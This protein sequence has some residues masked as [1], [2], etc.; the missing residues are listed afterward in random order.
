MFNPWIY[1]IVMF[2]SVE[3]ISPFFNQTTMITGWKNSGKSNGRRSAPHYLISLKSV[4]V[5]ASF[6]YPFAAYPHQ[7]CVPRDFIC[8]YHSIK[9]FT[10][11]LNKTTFT[12]KINEVQIISSE[13]S[14]ML[15]ALPKTCSP[16]SRDDFAATSTDN[17]S[18][19][20]LVRF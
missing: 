5:N 8:F 19:S 3:Q 12:I 15:I 14:P 16:C 17:T 1:I 6:P 9:N 2:H 4:I 11:Y 20:K 10:P 7:H 13:S 18:K